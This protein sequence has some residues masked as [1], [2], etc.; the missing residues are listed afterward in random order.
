[1]TLALL[2][3]YVPNQGDG[4]DYTLDYLERAARASCATPTAV[5]ARRRTA[6]SSR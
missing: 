3:A 4:W 2:Q 6:P 5:P 1:M